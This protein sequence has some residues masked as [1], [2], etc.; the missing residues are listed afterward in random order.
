MGNIFHR[1]D[2]KVL[3]QIEQQYKQEENYIEKD[4]TFPEKL[5]YGIRLQNMSSGDRCASAHCSRLRLGD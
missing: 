5:A 3:N 4:V 1:C 2:P